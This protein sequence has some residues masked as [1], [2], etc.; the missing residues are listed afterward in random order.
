MGKPIS[1]KFFLAHCGGSGYKLIATSTENL[2]SRT[3]WRGF[4]C[5]P[6]TSAETPTRPAHSMTDVKAF[7]VSKLDGTKVL[8]CKVDAGDS[9]DVSSP[10][11]HPL[12]SPSRSGRRAASQPPLS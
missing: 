6:R 11:V 4:G 2:A 12:P 10:A 5:F 9:T 8:E 1:K 3:N 7:I